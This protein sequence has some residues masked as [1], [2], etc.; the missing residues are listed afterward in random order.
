VCLTPSIGAASIFPECCQGYKPKDWKDKW[1]MVKNH[2]YAC[3]VDVGKLFNTHE[4]QV[5]EASA[6]IVESPLKGESN[7]E[8]KEFNKVD[9]AGR[10]I[11]ALSGQ[12]VAVL[13]V[14]A[15]DIIAVVTVHRDWRGGQWK[16]TKANIDLLTAASFYR[17]DVGTVV[18]NEG[19]GWPDRDKG[20][21]TE[22][23]TTIASCKELQRMPCPRLFIRGNVFDLAKV[24]K[25]AWPCACKW[26]KR[27]QRLRE[28]GL[29]KCPEALMQKD[30]K[31]DAFDKS[32]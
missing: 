26:C 32:D 11:W 25:K 13:E 19:E 1:R 30:I 18:W 21:A 15:E 8:L 10:I 14:A 5:K 23:L 20:I 29:L 3:Y 24:E 17:V 4:L 2:V 31:E 16:K 7:A 6:L 12:E 9:K 28:A 22:L 27:W